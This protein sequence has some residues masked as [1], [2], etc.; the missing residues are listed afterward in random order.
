MYTN[1]CLLTCA[2]GR[3]T[4]VHL[5]A[6][7]LG[8]HAP[9]RWVSTSMPLAV[10]VAHPCTWPLGSWTSVHLNAGRPCPWPLDIRAPGCCASVHLAAWKLDVFALGCWTCVRAC[11]WHFFQHHV[12]KYETAILGSPTH[13]FILQTF[14]HIT[15][16]QH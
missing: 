8:V 10:G 2:P 11:P 14:I 15:A 1:L 7:Q 16:R 6:G 3:W 5:T 13:I 4:S 12:R 9:G